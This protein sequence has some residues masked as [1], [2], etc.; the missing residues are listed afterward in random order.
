M[1]IPFLRG[2]VN[3]SG[4]S[5]IGLEMTKVMHEEKKLKRI[6]LDELLRQLSL[7][8]LKEGGIRFSSFTVG[9]LG[10]EKIYLVD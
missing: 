9:T 1:L 4:F 3:D 2:K 8:K 7:E 6:Q 10:G 5:F